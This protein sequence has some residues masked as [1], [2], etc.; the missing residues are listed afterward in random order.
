MSVAGLEKGIKTVEALQEAMGIYDYHKL[1]EGKLAPT[2][3]GRDTIGRNHVLM[4][5]G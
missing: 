4:K 5:S 3:G 1:Y 2:K